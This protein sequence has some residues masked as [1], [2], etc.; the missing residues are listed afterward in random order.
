MY[1]STTS[2]KAHHG[3]HHILIPPS[4]QFLHPR[5]RPR[6]RIRIG[7]I[8]NNNGRCGASVV[9]GREGTVS[10]LSGRVPDFKF[11]SGIVERYRLSEEGSCTFK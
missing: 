6:E 5:L 1:H 2:R 8:V 3:N 9:H 10:F 7:N 11:D 4:L